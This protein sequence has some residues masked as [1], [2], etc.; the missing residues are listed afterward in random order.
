MSLYSVPHVVSLFA[1]ERRVAAIGPERQLI[2]V[3]S[4]IDDDRVIG[5]SKI[6]K[7]LEQGADVL[8]ML[9]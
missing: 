8:V 9:D 6:V 3:V 4:R 1:A 7:F 2:A 5:N